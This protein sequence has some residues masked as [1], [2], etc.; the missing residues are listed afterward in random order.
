V[1]TGAFALSL[2]SVPLNI[3]ILK[4]LEEGPKPLADLRR[5]LGSPS[6]TTMRTQL[7]TLTQLGLLKRVQA[8]S[9]PGRV[10]YEL[11]RSAKD[12]AEV[13]R[14][15]EDWLDECP[16]GPVELGTQ[17]AKSTL[18]ALVDGWSCGIVRALAAKPLALTELSRII[19]GLSYPS[20]ERR[21][22]AMRLANQ[23]ERC[24]STNRGTPY[25]VTDFLR[26]ATEPLTAAARWERIR[27]PPG[28]EVAPIGGIEVEACFLLA[29]PRL[30]LPDDLS[31]TCR[32]AVELPAKRERA[33]VGVRAEVEEGRLSYCQTRLGGKASAW[34]TGPCGGWFSAV[35]EG[36]FNE[37]EIGGDS[38]LAY[39][40]LERLGARR[41]P[42][43]SGPGR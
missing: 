42:S 35:L 2:L 31:G 3:Q 41:S 17:H 30:Q 24:R 36:E 26:T 28:V 21:L 20:L 43:S 38:D 16:E 32:L 19:T 37:L 15:V 5:E 27:L 6:H 11:Q 4:A 23:I 39:S 1:R 29:L 18:K 12:L 22:G 33:L 40:L 14:V 34:V 9:F 13:S 25:V 8:S 10:D 7:R